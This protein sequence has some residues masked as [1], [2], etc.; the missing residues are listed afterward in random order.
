MCSIGLES[1]LMNSFQEP[2]YHCTDVITVK[3]IDIIKHPNADKLS[4][5][6][7]S[8][9]LKEY[10]VV[11][12]AKNINIG[13]VVPLAKVGATLNNNKVKVKLAT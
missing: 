11:C 8:D 1:T 4:I 2:E 12:G 6:R 9:R 10:L 3:I 7:L 5:C 13:Q